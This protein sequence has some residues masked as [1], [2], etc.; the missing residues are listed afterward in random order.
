MTL[1]DIRKVPEV[2][3]DDLNIILHIGQLATCLVLRIMSIL[4]QANG[5]P[6]V[7]SVDGVVAGQPEGI[8]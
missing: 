2:H 8:H 6:K 3:P 1:F 4:R 5:E 7:K